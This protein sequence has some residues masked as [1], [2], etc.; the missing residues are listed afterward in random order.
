M[1]HCRFKYVTEKIVEYQSL[2]LHNHEK[3]GKAL[4]RI[5]NKDNI[6]II[7]RLQPIGT[8]AFSSMPYT[9]DLY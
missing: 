7:I 2:C 5:M 3:L 8:A 9:K 4:D 6:A 1:A